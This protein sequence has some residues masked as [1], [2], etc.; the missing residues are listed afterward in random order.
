MDHSSWLNIVESGKPWVIT[1]CPDGIT[2]RRTLILH[3]VSGDGLLWCTRDITL[4]EGEIH[5]VEFANDI[6]DVYFTVDRPGIYEKKR[7]LLIAKF[8]VIS[9]VVFAV[10]WTYWT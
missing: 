6:E 2:A 9:A 4:V 8:G 10:A 7:N 3:C 1:T 5:R